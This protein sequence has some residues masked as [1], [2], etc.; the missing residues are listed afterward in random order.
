M[1][2]ANVL[3]VVLFLSPPRLCVCVCLRSTV[4]SVA[5]TAEPSVVMAMPGVEMKE[6]FTFK[7]WRESG[8]VLFTQMLNI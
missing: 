2:E 3:P 8:T 6:S 4:Y 5:S 7:V 1:L